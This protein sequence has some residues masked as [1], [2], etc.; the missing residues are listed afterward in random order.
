MQAYAIDDFYSVAAGAAVL[1]S[2]G[3]GSYQDALQ[4]VAELAGTGWTGTVTVKGYDGQSACAVLAMMGSPDAASSLTL[5]NVTNSIANTL[6]AFQTQ[7]Q[8]NLQ[9]AIPVE[10]GPINSLIPL[11]AATLSSNAITWVVDGDGAG[12]AVPEL[13]Q[14]TYSA[15]ATLAVSPCT[16]AND[17]GT[18][19][20][21][22][23]AT[24]QASTAAQAESLAG[25]IVAGFGSYSGIALWPSLCGNQ[26][27]L[28]NSYIPGTLSQAWKLGQYLLAAATP[29]ST[30]E[31]VNQIH[32]ITG[33]AA[34]A[35]VSNFYITEITQST[36]SA[37]LDAGVLRLD[38]H[39][40]PGQ[41]TE[42]HY[43]YNL[44]ENLIMYC[45]SRSTPDVI[46]PDSICYYSQSTGRGFSNA[47][48]DLALYFDSAQQVS[49]GKMV[50][51]I[52]VPALPQFYQA[53]NVSSSFASLL[54]RIGYAG[55]LPYAA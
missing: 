48:S 12:R 10:I 37:S 38:N 46:A 3:G 11:I 17:A 23:S 5:I 55:A 22:Q 9:C 36:T 15:S 30:A 45:S 47:S 53:R 13:A 43:I 51:V 4:I 34:Q 33:R 1:A 24:L 35:V 29:P 54:R 26:H 52:K 18:G 19:T 27:G 16:L 6:Q 28:S 20:P 25:G 49:T 42:T 44:N 14:T 21:A 32:A 40:D 7:I 31:V 50:S 8:D 41:S 39:I 2:G